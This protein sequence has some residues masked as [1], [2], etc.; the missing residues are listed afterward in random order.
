MSTIALV[1]PRRLLFGVGAL[2]ECAADAA[3]ALLRSHPLASSRAS[4]GRSPVVAPARA[5]ELQ[6]LTMWDSPGRIASPALE[7]VET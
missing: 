7:R 1:Q 3:D 5:P 2:S 4:S 6:G